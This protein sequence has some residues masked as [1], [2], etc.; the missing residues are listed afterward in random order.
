VIS[1]AVYGRND[2]HGYNLHRRVALSINCIAEVLTDESDEI[3]FVDWNT[4][5]RLPPFTTAIADLLTPKALS[6][7]KI[8]RVTDE[9]HNQH[10]GGK[11]HLPTVEP[12]ARNVALT[13]S[14]PNN[15]WFLSTNTDMVFLVEGGSLSDLVGGL[16]DSY[17]ALP[18]FELPEV[19]W[20]SLPRT[21]PIDALQT[22]STWR[23]RFSL[24]SR[25]NSTE[26][27]RYDAPG[28]FQL[29][30]RQTFLDIGGFE[31]EMLL[32]WH[33]D[34][35]MAKRLWMHFG[36]TK[37]LEQSVRGY[38]CNHTRSLTVHHGKVHQSNDLARFVDNITSPK[39]LSA[40]TLG[41]A[42]ET[43]SL[44]ECRPNKISL[45]E[46]SHFPEPFVSESDLL[47]PT[48]M[49]TASATHA[50]SA[51]LDPI[52]T[53][54]PNSQVEYYG[55]GPLGEL[56]LG[57]NHD[58]LFKSFFRN[59]DG[60]ST[61]SDLLIFDFDVNGL[62][63]SKFI[64]ETPVNVRSEIARIMSSLLDKSR[65]YAATPLEAQPLIAV[66]NADG[67]EFDRL[68]SLLLNAPGS[69][70]HS[71]VRVGVLRKLDRPRS[72]KSRAK[73]ALSSFVYRRMLTRALSQSSKNW[74]SQRRPS[75]SFV[76]TLLRLAFTTL[77]KFGTLLGRLL[78]IVLWLPSRLLPKVL[79]RRLW[80]YFTV[81]FARKKNIRS[82]ANASL[83]NV[84]IS[85]ERSISGTV[86][87]WAITDAWIT[88][89]QDNKGNKTAD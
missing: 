3:L 77:S 31:E 33:V 9:M 21:R 85:V 71:R 18:R 53:L 48:S 36:E 74:K 35:N 39:A 6:L 61:T 10:F 14:N 12:V 60:S 22:L 38:H 15:H 82:R 50:L 46:R 28:D 30:P 64:A 27:N 45:L 81:L 89:L 70:T 87:A 44:S 80:N 17:Y 83:R 52:I 56:L 47:N 34:S 19:F 65:E 32:G 75:V 2:S 86:G 1:V 25:V 5:K 42:T 20:E 69:Q 79:R 84:F 49:R 24:E 72:L 54:G 29:A 11:T 7:V 4:P 13:R 88:H 55:N 78:R 26:F 23:S 40:T 37:T 67:N 57:L 63:Q 59:G 68:I 16:S 73:L 8:L 66:V 62:S 58:G 76:I 41:L 43:I 51:L